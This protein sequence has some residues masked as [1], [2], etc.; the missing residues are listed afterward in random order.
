[1]LLNQY[2]VAGQKVATSY[3]NQQDYLNRIPSLANDAMMEIA[4]TQRKIS[5]MFDLADLEGED[6]GQMTRFLLPDD[7]FQF[8]TGDTQVVTNDGLV[9]H[10]NKYSTPGQ[11]YLLIPNEELE[12]NR[13]YYITYY[14]YPTLLSEKPND[15]DMLDN[16]PETHEAVAFYVAA[17]LVIHDDNFQFSAFYNKYEDKLS[18][19]G[20]GYTVEYQPVSGNGVYADA[21]AYS[22]VGDL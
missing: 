2:S 4:T 12:D 17:F 14:R 8:C 5:A 7:F 16:E 9:L 10:T 11:D 21:G 15:T 22:A 13:H 6:L 20:Q 18:R 19:F 3:N 1:M